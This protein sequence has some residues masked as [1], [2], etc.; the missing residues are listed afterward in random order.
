M[1]LRQR[2][3]LSGMKI[4]LHLYR[5]LF[6]LTLFLF[7]LSCQQYRF[8]VYNFADIKDYKKFPSRKLFSKRGTS[9]FSYSKAFN[10]PLKN[11]NNATLEEFLKKHKTVAFLVIRND[12]ILYENYFRN[13]DSTSIVPSFSMAKSYTSAL[14]GCAIQ[15]GLIHSVKDPI[16]NYIPELKKNGFDSVTIEHLLQMTSGLSFNENYFNP[17]GHVAGFYYGRQLRKKM[18][19]LKLKRKPGFAFEYLSGNSQLLGFVL[20][21]AL[22]NK[23]ITEYLQEKI[24]TPLEMEGDASWSIDQKKNGIEKTFCC[25]NATARDF[26]RFGRLYLHNGNWNGKQLV[27]REWVLTSTVADTSQ[28]GATFYKYQWWLPNAFKGDFMANGFLGQYIYVCPEKNIIIVRLGKSNGG[29]YWPSVFR[30]IIKKL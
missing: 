6:L 27:P 19:N 11:D 13:R 8:I 25:L 24:W 20:E 5:I 3:Y 18:I 28:G 1:S 29:V 9:F 21:R 22:K 17:F 26:S 23:T 10:V 15:D 30:S 14:I 16:T 7:I 2:S 4:S 12:S